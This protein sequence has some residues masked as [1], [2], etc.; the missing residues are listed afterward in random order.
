MIILN[1]GVPRSGTVLV[2]AILRELLRENGIAT[3]QANPH[4]PALARLL[5]NLRMNGRHLHK[6]VLIHTHSW[7]DDAAR[8][9]KAVPETVILGNFRDPRDV[10]VSLMRLH[11]HDFATAMKMTIGNFNVFD[12][13]CATA[14]VMMIP[15]ELLV[16]QKRAHIYQ[17]A[18]R[19][20]LWPRLDQVARID[21]A[22]SIDRHK[23]VMDKVN[24]GEID[25]LTRRPNTNRVLVEDPKTLINDRHI[26]SGVSGRW[27][28]ELSETEQAEAT[29]RLTPLLERFGYA[30][31]AR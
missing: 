7:D 1:A 11:D 22:T 15:Y 8:Q 26:Q 18:R 25:G 6:T 28:T 12:N 13:M 9:V 23:G 27:R 3:G 17:I 20:G 21:A 19:I 5:S 2:N 10:C 30:E 29:E 4:G 31:D 16:T 14:D 24:S